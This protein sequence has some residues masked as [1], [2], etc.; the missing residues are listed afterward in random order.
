MTW[1][2]A[3]RSNYKPSSHSLSIILSS[4]FI[5]SFLATLFVMYLMK[6]TAWT[7]QFNIFIWNWIELKTGHFLTRPLNFFMIRAKVTK[8][9]ENQHFKLVQMRFSCF[10]KTEMFIQLVKSSLSFPG[11]AIKVIFKLA[12]RGSGARYRQL[13]WFIHHVHL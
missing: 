6:P 13:I 1:K 12:L 2:L 7:H 3:S 5:Y 8:L 11:N 9:S 10:K 4:G